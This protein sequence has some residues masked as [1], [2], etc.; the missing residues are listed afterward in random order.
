M[1][2]MSRLTRRGGFTLLEIGIAAALGMVVSGMVLAAYM[3]ANRAQ[4]ITAGSSMLKLSGQ[5]TLSN[6]YSQLNQSRR[7]FD[8]G[9]ATNAFLALLPIDGYSATGLSPGPTPSEVVLPQVKSGGSFLIALDDGT[10]VPGGQAAATN[11]PDFDATSVGN[12]LFFLSK[13][14]RVGLKDTATGPEA[15]AFNTV[16]FNI[17]TYRFQYY[18]LAHRTLPL[19]APPVRGTDG[20]TYQLMRW[21]SLPYL[22]K[23]EVEQWMTALMAAN[24]SNAAAAH[25]FLTTKLAAVKAAYAGALDLSQP[26]ATAFYD[27]STTDYATLPAKLPAP[28]LT[29][30]HFG[31]AIKLLMHGSFGEEFV[32]FNTKPPTNATPVT[33]A[34]PLASLK[35]SNDD[36]PMYAK[37]TDTP[38][39]FEVMIAGP[40]S[41]RRVLTRLTLAARTQPGNVMMGEAYQQITQTYDY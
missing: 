11:N 22:D 31:T 32:A 27:L 10:G 23:T 36:V 17:H 19:H 1:K 21:D 15:T 3:G 5:A 41:A 37:A 38:M 8:R 34:V 35:G 39:G 25:T 26:A 13:D 12:A 4:A 14:L 6:L 40:P 20:Y 16:D 2:S 30:G 33:V 28:T 7:I 24:S 9:A 29:T 18:Y